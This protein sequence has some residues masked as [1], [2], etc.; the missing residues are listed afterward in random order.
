M[1]YLIIGIAVAFNILIIKTKLGRKRYEDA[2]LDTAVLVG[3]SIVFGGSFAGLVAS[4]IASA[5]VSIFFL[6]SPPKF[7]GGITTESQSFE[8]A[9]RI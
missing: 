1:E 9:L 3:L 6:I 5:I 7:L 8:D 2:A 4:T